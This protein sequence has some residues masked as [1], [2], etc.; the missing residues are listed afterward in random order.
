VGIDGLLLPPPLLGCNT[1][2]Q[3]RPQLTERNSGVF[4]FWHDERRFKGGIDTCLV[5]QALFDA[6]VRG[7]GGGQ[8][9]RC[10]RSSAAHRR[11]AP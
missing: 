10:S 1:Q 3:R 8:W 9:W 5:Q 11:H 6:G 7:R 2:A 4:R